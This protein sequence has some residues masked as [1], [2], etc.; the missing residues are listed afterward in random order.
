M[1][2]LRVSASQNYEARFRAALDER[3]VGDGG[4]EGHTMAGD[5]VGI[6]VYPSPS[7][8]RIPYFDHDK[9]WV[10]GVVMQHLYST[11]PDI[12]GWDC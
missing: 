7:R 10:Q 2:K 11:C 12:S 4:R 6:F 3:D 9:T 1:E 8:R 5:C